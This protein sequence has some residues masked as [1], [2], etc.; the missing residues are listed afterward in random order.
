MVALPMPTG[1]KSEGIQ[2]FTARPGD[3]LFD[4]DI[5]ATTLLVLVLF[6]WIALWFRHNN[7][8]N[9]IIVLK[10]NWSTS[11]FHPTLWFCS[12]NSLLFC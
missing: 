8:A 12:Q 3:S 7:Q 4:A 6:H 2:D 11:S 1:E 10:P 9:H 5:M